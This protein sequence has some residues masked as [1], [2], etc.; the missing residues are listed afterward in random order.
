MA[1]KRGRPLGSVSKERRMKKSLRN[2]MLKEVVWNLVE[3]S[4]NDLMKG[5]T[6]KMQQAEIVKLIRVLHSM[7]KDEKA[8]SNIID[9]DEDNAENIQKQLTEWLNVING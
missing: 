4:V 9:E 6:P 3:D 8:L 2:R 1:G 7:E 5:E